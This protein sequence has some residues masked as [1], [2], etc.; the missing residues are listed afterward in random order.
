L[1]SDCFFFIFIHCF[2]SFLIVFDLF[3]CIS[4]FY[5]VFYCV[6]FIIFKHTRGI[7]KSYPLRGYILGLGAPGITQMGPLELLT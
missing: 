1:I 2:L 3:L 7:L 4:S 5:Y 6:S